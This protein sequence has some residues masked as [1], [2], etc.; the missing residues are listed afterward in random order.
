LIEKTKPDAPKRAYRKNGFL[1]ARAQVTVNELDRAY[2][3]ALGGGNLSAGI[4]LACDIV[5][6]AK[7]GK[8]AQ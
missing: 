4:A 2:L 8:A 3:I 5:R 1:T 7:P 6:K